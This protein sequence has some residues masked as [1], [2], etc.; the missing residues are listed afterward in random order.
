M[1]YRCLV[2]TYEHL[3][4]LNFYIFQVNLNLYFE[5]DGG[6]GFTYTPKQ[7]NENK[8]SCPI[9]S[10]TGSSNVEKQRQEKKEGKLGHRSLSTLLCNL[11][12]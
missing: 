1:P 7:T 2:A 10:G 6:D 8:S 9:R 11:I 5:I 3:T 12:N 4:I